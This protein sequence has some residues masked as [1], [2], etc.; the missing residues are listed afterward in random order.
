MSEISRIKPLFQLSDAMMGHF[1][2]KISI[3]VKGM[4]LSGEIIIT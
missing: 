4:L 2:Q 3:R 1:R